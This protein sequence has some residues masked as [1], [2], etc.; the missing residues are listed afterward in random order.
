MTELGLRRL[1]NLALLALP[2]AQDAP[3][4]RYGEAPPFGKGGPEV[5]LR[6]LRQYIP[7][8][9][10][11]FN[12]LYLL[13]AGRPD[14]GFIEAAKARG[15]RVVVNQNGVYYPAVRPGDWQT[16]NEPMRRM[17]QLADYIFYQSEFSRTGSEKFLGPASAP[18]EI[19]PNAVDTGTF[20]PAPHCHCSG[21][22]VLLSTGWIVDEAMLASFANL[23]AALK[24]LRAR[25]G[26]WRF[27]FA[28]A[29][30]LGGSCSDFQPRAEDL[31][32]QSGLGERI[33]LL[34]RYGRR[35]APSVFQQGHIY[36]HMKSMD[37]CPN[38]VLEALASG[39]PIVYPAVGGVC[40]LVDEA[41]G[42]G[43]PAVLNW[44]RVC[45]PCPEDYAAA[46]CEAMERRDELA[47]GARARAVA[48]YDVRPWV[49]RHREVF[50]RLLR[51]GG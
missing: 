24:I 23:L 13:G 20:R 29:F 32:R 51:Q 50:A 7:E 27:V 41:C 14:F 22:F 8:S 5:K 38:G 11:C 37:W 48:R 40:E 28:G 45:L 34:S 21:E 33:Q 2:R 31:I 10:L 19:L 43:V 17:R 25:R 26:D 18:W 42:I 12:I 44:E 4:V 49:A 47:H 16:A 9:R 6:L 35:N 1:L 30:S 46:I 15:I 39:L 36:L 3:H